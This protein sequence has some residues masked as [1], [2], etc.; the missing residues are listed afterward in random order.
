MPHYLLFFAYL[1]S[2]RSVIIFSFGTS[3]LLLLLLLPF[4]SYLGCFCL[5]LLLLI[6]HIEKDIALGYVWLLNLMRENEMEMKKLD[7]ITVRDHWIIY[8]FFYFHFILPHQILNPNT[9]L[10]F[11]THAICM[12]DCQSNKQNHGRL[13][14]SFLLTYQYRCNGTLL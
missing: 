10:E 9:T 14:L 12:R 2:H 8:F 13:M 5:S 3:L 11:H 7:N 1:F 4:I 6:I